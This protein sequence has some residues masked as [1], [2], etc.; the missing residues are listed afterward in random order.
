[1]TEERHEEML[2]HYAELDR[3][4]EDPTPKEALQRIC[5]KVREYFDSTYHYEDFPAE[6]IDNLRKAESVLTEIEVVADVAQRRG[7]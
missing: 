1:M 6:V 2:Q 3:M 4:R 5:V 7:A